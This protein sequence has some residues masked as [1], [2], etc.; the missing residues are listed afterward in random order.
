MQKKRKGGLAIQEGAM[1]HT[2]K[3]RLVMKEGVTQRRKKERYGEG[4]NG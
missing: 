4:R 1:H 2:G 3:E